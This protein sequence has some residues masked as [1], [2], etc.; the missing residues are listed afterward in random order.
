MRSI[1]RSAALAATVLVPLLLT[2]LP[3]P[4]VLAVCD[5]WPQVRGRAATPDGLARRVRR[6]LAFGR[7]PWR[8]TC[9]TRSLVLYTLL[10]QHGYR[11]KLHLGVAGDARGF[12][13]HAW[14]TLDDRPVELPATVGSQ[15]RRL[16]VHG[17]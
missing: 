16:L 1:E 7:G 5:Q 14:I 11:P 12:D 6:W 8:S 17:G 13:A 4:N 3:L 15:Y 2:L 9:L 10:R